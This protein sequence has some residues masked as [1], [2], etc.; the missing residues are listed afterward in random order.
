M[1]T[2]LQRA[3]EVLDDPK[4]RNADPY[5]VILLEEGEEIDWLAQTYLP[6]KGCMVNLYRLVQPGHPEAFI[7]IY[8]GDGGDYI[9]WQGPA[10]SRHAIEKLVGPAPEGWTDM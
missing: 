1:S 4:L 7:A 2:L 3:R 8:Q 5:D 6:A 9:K 10:K